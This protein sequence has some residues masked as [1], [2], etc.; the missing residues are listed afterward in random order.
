MR[1]INW[2]NAFTRFG[3]WLVDGVKSN[4]GLLVGGASMITL[5]LI[6][7]KLNIPYQVLTDPYSTDSWRE[8]SHYTSRHEASLDIYLVPNNPVEAA[9]NSIYSNALTCT[10]DSD[11]YNAAKEIY[12]I[13][14][15][16]KEDA[17]DATK[18][19]CI[20]LLQNLGK[21]MTF[22]SDRS[23]IIRLVSQIGK[24]EL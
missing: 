14:V 20:T 3:T 13:L 5:A 19:Y 4:G 8:K 15:A 10:F 11:R 22:D 12:A 6:C 18:T 2:T 24:G 9:M 21:K 16:H 17:T 7:K 23:K 1:K